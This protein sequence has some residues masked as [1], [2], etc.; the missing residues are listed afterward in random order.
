MKIH[1]RKDRERKKK[2][3]EREKKRRTLLPGADIF[4]QG[5]KKHTYIK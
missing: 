2:K 4:V 5:K 3:R 1:M